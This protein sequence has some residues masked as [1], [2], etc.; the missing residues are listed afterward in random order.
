M[1][2]YPSSKPFT[3]TTYASP[4]ASADTHSASPRRFDEFRLHPLLLAPVHERFG[5]NGKTTAIQTLALRHFLPDFEAPARVLLG[6]ETGSGKT[7]AYLLPLFSHLKSTDT[8]PTPDE[9]KTLNPRALVLSPT[10]ELTRQST[11]MAKTLCHTAKLSVM[12]M[13]STKYGGIG[14]RRGGVDVLFGTGAMTRRML[15]LASPRREVK[16]DEEDVRTGYV[17]VDRLEWVVI[18]EADVLLGALFVFFTSS[19]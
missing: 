9:G 14:D 5:E 1:N 15:G 12:G 13:S 7:L 19:G 11:G 6:A 3:P 2:P 18:D 17:G 4:D 8:G 16:E 10:H